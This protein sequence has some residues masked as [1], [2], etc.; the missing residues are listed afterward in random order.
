[1]DRTWV[2]RAARAVVRAAVE[3][4]VAHRSC[5]DRSPPGGR[6]GAPAARFAPARRGAQPPAALRTPRAFALSQIASP[7]TGIA[8]GMWITSSPLGGTRASSSGAGAG[9]TRLDQS[10][11]RADP[12]EDV[13]QA[14][15]RVHVEAVQRG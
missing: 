4:A 5:A 11:K 3:R 15:L 10:L 7:K 2:A 13:L 8:S 12:I 9:R 14:T 6:F 1:V